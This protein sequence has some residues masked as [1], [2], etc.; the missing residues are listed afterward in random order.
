[1]KDLLKKM[2]KI[3]L[4]DISE[5]NES[6]KKNIDL[7]VN[8][9]REDELYFAIDGEFEELCTNIISDYSEVVGREHIKT[10]NW[11]PEEIDDKNQFITWFLKQFGAYEVWTITPE[12]VERKEDKCPFVNVAR[13]TFTRY[14]EIYLKKVARSITDSTMFRNKHSIFVDFSEMV[15][16]DFVTGIQRV[17]NA[18]YDNIYSIYQKSDSFDVI[19]VYSEPGKNLTIKCDCT[20]GR[21]CKRKIIRSDDVVQ[22]HDGDYLI[23][24][25]IN[26]VN[27]YTKEHYYRR[28][29]NRGIKVISVLYDLIP[30]HYPEFYSSEL[31]ENFK[32]YLVAMT[33]F[34]GVMAISKATMD[35][36][37]AWIKNKNIT[38][39]KDFLLDY[40]HLGC[41]VDK[42]IP[43]KRR[44]DEDSGLPKY[45][46]SKLTFTIV[47]TIEPRKMHSQVL[48]AFE[49]LW[50]RQMDVNLVFV[51]KY[52][53]RMETF[54]KRIQQHK[55][56]GKHFFW[57]QGV[58]DEYLEDI[59][60]ASSAIIMASLTEGFGLPIIEA[61]HYGKKIIVRDIPVFREVAGDSAYYFNTTD[62]NELA[63]VLLEWIQLEKDGKIHCSSCVQS[64]TWREASVS[65]LEKIGLNMRDEDK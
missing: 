40:F 9:S 56:L 33:Q 55:E 46:G 30:I 51:G 37:S 61:A 1:M 49:I 29:H 4:F 7:F 35:D 18:L 27:V 10:W 11:Y 45:L 14:D 52:G 21:F 57:L 60:R 42:A 12:G 16:I 53:W 44:Q 32:K 31:P 43:S 38:L 47:A 5:I 48:D 36:F 26:T 59:Y 50:E 17:C 63:T 19:P 34:S 8:E 13:W 23:L 58:S 39:R 64:L 41:D 2:I 65:F 22:F 15:R 20:E 6:N 3:L 62:S 28:L 25:D 54:A 24:P